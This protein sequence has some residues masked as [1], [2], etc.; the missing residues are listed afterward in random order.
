MRKVVE[1]GTAN[2]VRVP[3]VSV[4]G[5]TGTAQNPHGNDHALFV[6]FAPIE[7]PTVAMAV[8]AENSGHGGTVCAPIAAQVLKAMFVHDST[9]VVAGPCHDA[10][11]FRGGLTMRLRLPHLDVPLAMATLGLITIW[12]AHRVQR[13]LGTGRARGALG[14]AVTVVRRGGH[15]RVDR[16]RDPLSS[17]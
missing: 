15:R 16:R 2:S 4:G 8:V 3:G 17:V 9:T 10:R 6:C 1:G 14:Q 12:S 11:R 13:D 7:A 5:K